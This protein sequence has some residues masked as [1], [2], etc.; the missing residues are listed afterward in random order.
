M[1][2]QL[3]LNALSLFVGLN[4]VGKSN[5][6]KALN[7]FFN[8]ETETGKS[9]A[10]PEDYSKYAPKRLK[11]AEEITIEIIILAPRNYKGNKDIKWVKVWRKDGLHVDKITFIDGTQF[12]ERTKLYSWLKN[13]RFVYVPAVRGNTYF[14]SLL[15]QLHDTLAETIEDELREAGESFINKIKTKTKGMIN[16]I[17]T[18]LSLN[19]EIRLPPNLQALFKTLDFATSEGIF[20][21]SLANRG[22]GIKTRHIPIILKFI[23]E[24]L[25]INKRKGAANVNMIWGYEEPENNLEMI[26][27]FELAKE[28]MEYSSDLQILLTTH[29]AGFYSLKSDF[30]DTTN[31][32]KV[33]KP[34]GTPATLE[35]VVDTRSIDQEMGL[36]PLVA[37][38]IEDKVNEIKKLQREVEGYR[39]EI[40]K[41]NKHVVFVE[42]DDEVRIFSKIIEI[43]GM[44]DEIDVRRDAFGCSGVKQQLISWSWVASLKNL[45]AIGL[46]DCDESG[47]KEKSKTEAEIQYKK[48]NQEGKVKAIEYSIPIHLRNIKQKIHQFPIEIEEMY[49]PEVWLRCEKNKW[50]EPR[51]TKEIATFATPD[52][53]TQSL[54]DKID[55][56]MFSDEELRYVYF[57]IPDRHKNKV[58][59]YLIT[60]DRSSFTNSNQAIIDFFNAKVL[61]F[62]K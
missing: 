2:C 3:P 8:N 61:N 54:K 4:D 43:S 25:N 60:R 45:K 53:F 1:S 6:L 14:E 15:A 27:S 42:G 17:D 50:L 37:P 59:K 38:Y 7:L 21:I 49:S 18:R 12:P 36:M 13:I 58:S 31:L 30:P 35:L 48:A 26:V 20:N 56:F 47:K 16:G 40:D 39:S 5:V 34:K 52:L 9:I 19:S 41:F 28:F 57:K 29:S 23:S 55:S 46:F 11:K 32:F 10:F 22:D 44:I 24:Q 51:S 33:K 62:F